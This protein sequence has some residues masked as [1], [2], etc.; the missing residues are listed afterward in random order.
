[1]RRRARRLATAVGPFQARRGRYTDGGGNPGH[2]EGFLWQPTKLD[3]CGASWKTFSN[4]CRL[5]QSE[6]CWGWQSRCLWL[7]CL[8]HSRG[9]NLKYRHV[10]YQCPCRERLLSGGHGTKIRAILPWPFSS[11]VLLLGLDLQ[12]PDPAKALGQ[13]RRDRVIAAGFF[14]RRVYLPDRRGCI[15]QACPHSIVPS[16]MEPDSCEALSKSPAQTVPAAGK[17]GTWRAQLA[18]VAGLK[19]SICT[20]SAGSVT[21][22]GYASP[23]CPPN[24]G[25]HVSL[26]GP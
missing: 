11:A 15:Q 5:S 23:I 3:R 19:R 2:R 1:L 7:S 18:G 4:R 26:A 20:A 25:Q 14:M 17:L 22:A 21:A 9:E 13:P 16:A 12:T 8:C 24:S 10:A 6:Y